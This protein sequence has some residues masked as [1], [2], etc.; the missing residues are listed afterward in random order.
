MSKP[1]FNPA[2]CDVHAELRGCW[3]FSVQG[4]VQG[5]ATAA[6][7]SGNRIARATPASIRAKLPAAFKAR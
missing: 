1:W 6:Q 5:I 2:S 7:I 3:T 4:V